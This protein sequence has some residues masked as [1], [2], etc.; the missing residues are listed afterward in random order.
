MHTIR[1]DITYA[2]RTLLKRPTFAAVAILTLTLAIGVNVAVF[3]M[4]STV[5]LQPLGYPQAQQLV[6]LSG[7]GRGAGGRALNLSRPDFRDFEQTNRTF[8]AMGAFDAG[9]EQ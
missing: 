5:V 4:V 7:V 6:K 3:A 9:I 2:I 8:E 1:Q